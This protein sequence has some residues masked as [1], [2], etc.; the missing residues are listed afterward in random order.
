MSRQKKQKKKIYSSLLSLRRSF[1][2]PTEMWKS[3][4]LIKTIVSVNFKLLDSTIRMAKI[5]PSTIESSREGDLGGSSSSLI[6]DILSAVWGA[7]KREEA[8]DNR[9]KSVY[10][11][12]HEHENERDFPTE[13]M[14]MP[15]RHN[16]M[17][18]CEDGDGG[19]FTS[20]R[21]S[22]WAGHEMPSR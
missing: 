18:R 3:R 13:R 19:N 10:K 20:L 8:R 15:P 5:R 2:I 12:F 11:L 16:W 9:I 17:A 1:H 4:N 14:Y 21:V 22:H 6:G 7:R